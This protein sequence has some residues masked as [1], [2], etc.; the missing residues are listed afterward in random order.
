MKN[1]RDLATPAVASRRNIITLATD[2]TEHGSFPRRGE[3]DQLWV[4]MH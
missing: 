2:K 4:P 1:R 3:S